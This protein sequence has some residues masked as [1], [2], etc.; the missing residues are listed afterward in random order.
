MRE[1]VEIAM[2]A[3][4]EMLRQRL[5]PADHERLA[6]E[7]LSGLIKRPSMTPGA[8]GPAGGAS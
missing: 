1:T 3:A 5:T 7:Y 4:E 6:D 8:A 2:T